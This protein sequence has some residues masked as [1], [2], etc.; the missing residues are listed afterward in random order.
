MFFQQVSDLMEIVCVYKVIQ[1]KTKIKKLPNANVE[2]IMQRCEA[3][4]GH[5]I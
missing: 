1:T 2:V 3:C 5:D 4:N